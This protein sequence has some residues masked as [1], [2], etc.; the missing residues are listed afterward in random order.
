MQVLGE[1]FIDPDTAQQYRP[2]LKPLLVPLNA[3]NVTD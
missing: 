3:V 1:S 2:A